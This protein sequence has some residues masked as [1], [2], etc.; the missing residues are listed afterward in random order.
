MLRTVLHDSLDSGDEITIVI[1]NQSFT[2]CVV[3]LSDTW[4]K[5]RCQEIDIYEGS[6]YLTNWLIKL[7]K[8]N[9]VCS[10]NKTV[11]ISDVDKLLHA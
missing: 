9:S 11:K 3:E 6:G 4:V 2:G 7:D 5:V 1:D 10:S 8:I